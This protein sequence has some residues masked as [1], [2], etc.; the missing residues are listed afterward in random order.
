MTERGARM[1]EEGIKPSE[2]LF[3]TFTDAG[4]NEMKA[5]IAKKC[6]TRGLH[7][8]GDDIQAMTFNTFAYR[9]VKDNFED[10]GFTTKPMVVDDIRNSV[11]ITQ[12][13]DE[14]PVA[15][16]DYLNYDVNSP[17][18]LGAL[19]WTCLKMQPPKKGFTVSSVPQGFQH[20]CPCMRTTISV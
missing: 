9:I 4:A 3:I 5:R 19:A 10:C 1:F 6:E 17:N 14:N 13:L 11:I 8:S 2:V 20:C 7:V 15:G 12:L 18:C 16:L